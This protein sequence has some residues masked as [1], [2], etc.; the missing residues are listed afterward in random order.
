MGTGVEVNEGAQDGNG[1]GSGDGLVVPVRGSRLPVRCHEFGGDASRGFPFLRVGR[2]T[3]PY[4]L[5]YGQ[6]Y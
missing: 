4:T 5:L 2:V 6:I 3:T 1:D